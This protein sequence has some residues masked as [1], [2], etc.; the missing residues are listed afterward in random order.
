MFEGDYR[1]FLERE[2]WH[3]ETID[4]STP[5]TAEQKAALFDKMT[6]KEIRRKRSE[7]ITER[8]KKMKP[9]EEKIASA[10]RDIEGYE[11]KIDEL[12]EGMMKASKA[13]DGNIIAD[14]SKK[15]HKYQSLLEVRFAEF[16]SFYEEKEKIESEYNGYLQ[17]LE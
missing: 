5:E 3:D 15:I 11:K 10:E 2:G 8:G 12:N 14:I 6:K 9:L 13:S 4:R 1:Y 17:L 7:I 16:E